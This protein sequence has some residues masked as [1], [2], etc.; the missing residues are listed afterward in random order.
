MTRLMYDSTAPTDIPVTAPMVAGYVD[1]LYAWSAAGWARFPNSVKVRIAVSPFTN[2]GHVLDVETGDATPAQAPGW[3]RMRIAAGISRPTLYVNRSNWAAV[4]SACAGLPV[5]FWIATLDGSQTVVPPTGVIQPIAVQYA[6]ST[7]AGGH[8]DLSTVVDFWA[9]VDGTHGGGGGSVTE[10]NK[11]TMYFLH[12][13]DNNNMYVV[14]ED[15]FQLKT[16]KRHITLAEWTIYED[17][18]AIY[19]DVT[20]APLQAIPDATLPVLPVGPQG[21]KG[22]TGL[23]GPTGPPGPAGQNF[24]DWLRSILG[25]KTS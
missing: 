20:T 25:T 24:I 15:P 21:P 23:T 4:A 22:D 1:G 5:D 8:F 10:G 19:K 11:I 7:L 16:V 13:T 18:G 14:Y 3:A 9:A 12:N 2:D 17:G 6:N